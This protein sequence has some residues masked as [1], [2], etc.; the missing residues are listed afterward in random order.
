MSTPNEADAEA[1]QP[2]RLSAFVI[3]RRRHLRLTQEEVRANGGPSNAT[4]TAIEGGAMRNVRF[5][6][7]TFE[8][9]DKGLD[10]ER[11]TTQRVMNGEDIP[12]DVKNIPRPEGIK[13]LQ[14]SDEDITA[15]LA[16]VENHR[17]VREL[18]RRLAIAQQSI[19][20]LE[21]LESVISKL[22]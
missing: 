19:R 1:V 4:L 7:A 21:E 6:R 16:S 5:N 17:L 20:R 3:G 10:L 18:D 9:L 22:R 8:K 11:G 14:L 13:S 12:V 15:V 2:H